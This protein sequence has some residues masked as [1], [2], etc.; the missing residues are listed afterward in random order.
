M[1]QVIKETELSHTWKTRMKI[2]LSH[3]A[4]SRYSYSKK[5]LKS[6]ILLGSNQCTG[7]DF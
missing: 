4:K 5:S 2:K 1:G 3:R 7:Y 6:M